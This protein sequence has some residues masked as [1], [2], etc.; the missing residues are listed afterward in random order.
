MMTLR[1]T[2]LLI[3]LYCHTSLRAQTSSPIERVILLYV[4]GV[5]PRAIE[6][7]QLKNILSLKQTGTT[8]EKGIMVFPVHPTIWPYGEHH[9]T[10]FPNI[11]TLAGT[12]FIR[13]DQQFFHHDLPANYITLHAAGSNAYRSMND[14]FHYVL[15][16]S[17]INDSMLIDF[18]I[19]AFEREADIDFAR[20]HLQE[21]GAAGREGSGK[22]QGNVAWA[23]DIFAAD[24]PYQAA[25]TNA[26]RQIGRLFSYLKQSGKWDST[27]IVFMGDGQATAGWHLYMF[28]DAWLTPII[29]SGPGIKRNFKIAYAE[30]IDVIPTLAALWNIKLTNT[31]GG[32][33][34]VLT[35][36]F[37]NS[38]VPTEPHPRWLEKINTQIKQY[39]QLKAQADL[40]S[41]NDPKMN[42]LLMELMHEGLSAHQFYYFDRILEWQDAET[43]QKMHQ[44]NQWVIDKLEKALAG[45]YEFGE[46]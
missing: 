46:R 12:A 42:L 29:F 6:K 44:S 37:E 31:N 41:A 3:A 9:T 38:A 35:E 8:I 1:L 21:P 10:S 30:N 27:L 11:A 7:Y 15:T 5:H 14:G 45:K 23:Q 39:I 2:I 24:S 32:T 43:L 22:E 20:I 33:G 13:A 18:V 25:M 28:E 26:D 17:G 36:V 34:R 40:K 4:D 19:D 16:R